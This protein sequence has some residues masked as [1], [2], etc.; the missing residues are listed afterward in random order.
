MNELFLLYL[1]PTVEFL[2]DSYSTV[3]FSKSI[4]GIVP[5]YYESMPEIFLWHIQ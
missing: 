3:I 5:A 4:V 1:Y 2:S